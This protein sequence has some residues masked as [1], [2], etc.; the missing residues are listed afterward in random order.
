MAVIPW[1]SNMFWIM[2][3]FD[4]KHSVQTSHL[5]CYLLSWMSQ[6]ASPHHL[7]S[8]L[9]YH[10][11]CMQRNGDSWYGSKRLYF[12]WNSC[13]RADIMSSHILCWIH[14]HTH[15]HVILL[16]WF[17]ALCSSRKAW[18][19]IVSSHLLQLNIVNG[20]ILNVPMFLTVQLFNF[21]C[22]V[23]KESK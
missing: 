19:L 15:T 17:L 13:Y 22:L 12:L 4:L 16:V 7:C 20:P 8:Q 23:K 11:L 2:I 10:K 5:C 3:N 14:D 1:L 21:V 6:H 9:S 18:L